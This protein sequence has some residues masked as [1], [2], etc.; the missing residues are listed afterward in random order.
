MG[1]IAVVKKLLI[2]AVLIALGVVAASKRLR[3]SLQSRPRARAT[4]WPWRLTRTAAPVAASATP[5]S[6]AAVGRLGTG[7]R[8]ARAGRGRP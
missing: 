1:R 2:L 3:P 6:A 4:R 8:D 7:L 5:V